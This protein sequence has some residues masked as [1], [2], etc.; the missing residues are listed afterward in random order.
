MDIFTAFTTIETNGDFFK[1]FIIGLLVGAIVAHFVFKSI[2]NILNQHIKDLK[3]ELDQAKKEA[4]AFKDELIKQ[5]NLDMVGS[6][7]KDDK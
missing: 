6:I 1:G 4:K 3:A 2:T 7:F 5:Q